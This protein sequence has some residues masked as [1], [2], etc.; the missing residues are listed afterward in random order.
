[1]IVSP[2][3]SREEA[4]FEMTSI[5]LLRVSGLLLFPLIALFY[6]FRLIGGHAWLSHFDGESEAGHTIMAIGMVF[7]LVPAA[8]QTPTIVLWNVIL[9]AAASLWFTGRL[10]TRRPLFALVLQK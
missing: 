4:L 2:S 10:L 1:M 9:F 5:D 8:L 3:L 6:L 7:M